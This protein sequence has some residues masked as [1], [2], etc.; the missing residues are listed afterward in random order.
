MN[1]LG[2]GKLA[3]G[4]FFV[5][6]GL[7]TLEDWIAHA[8]VFDATLSAV[9]MLIGVGLIVLEPSDRKSGRP[10][11]RRKRLESEPPNIGWDRRTIESAE[12]RAKG[13]E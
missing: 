2:L 12:R 8:R 1:W 5:C 7:W 10:A 6:G 13:T 9:L 4:S 3:C 11:P